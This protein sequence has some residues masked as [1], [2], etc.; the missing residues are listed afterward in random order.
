MILN[1]VLYE[2]VSYMQILT[3]NFNIK[4]ASTDST[5]IY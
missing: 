2:S 4:N 3:I 1:G 5:N